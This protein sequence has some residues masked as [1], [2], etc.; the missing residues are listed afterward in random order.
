MLHHLML[1]F[2][3]NNTELTRFC[4]TLMKAEKSFPSCL[5]IMTLYWRCFA[6]LIDLWKVV[7]TVFCKVS[8]SNQ[9]KVNLKHYYVFFICFSFVSEFPLITAS[10]LA[11]EDWYCTLTSRSCLSDFLRT[12]VTVMKKENSASQR[13]TTVNCWGSNP[14]FAQEYV[15]FLFFFNC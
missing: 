9:V 4:T 5:H 8:K 14:F 10:R 3:C 1:F 2:P 6:E 15:G 11:F 7:Q 12:V 13:N